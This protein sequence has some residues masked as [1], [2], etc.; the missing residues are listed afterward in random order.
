MW[1]WHGDYW[2]IQSSSKAKFL[3][4]RYFNIGNH[5]ATIWGTNMNLEVPQYKN[6]WKWEHTIFFGY[7]YRSRCIKCNKLYKIEYYHNLAWYCKVNFKI[8]PP[9][10]KTKKDKLCLH[11]FK[12]V[13]YKGKHQVDSNT[14]LFWRHRFNKE[15]YAKKYYEL[16]ESQSRSICLVMG[17]V[18]S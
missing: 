13:N 10:I 15:W 1:H 16:H 14:C 12:H 4:N 8:N 6:C 11:S 5:F 9:K 3:I 7:T 17:K 18:S 2:D